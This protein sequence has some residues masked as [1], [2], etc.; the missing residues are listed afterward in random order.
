[1]HAYVKSYQVGALYMH[2]FK[3]YQVKESSL[4]SMS[5]KERILDFSENC[6]IS[7]SMLVCPHENRWPPLERDFGVYEV[8]EDGIGDNSGFGLKVCLESLPLECSFS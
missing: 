5:D 7:T 8:A 6:W 3:S 2:M 4:E 1:M